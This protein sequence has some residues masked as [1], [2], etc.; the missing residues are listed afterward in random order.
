MTPNDDEPRLAELLRRTDAIADGAPVADTVPT[1][2]PTLDRLLGGGFRR[3]DLI[4]LGGDVGTGKSA[5]ALAIAL[6]AA[7]DGHPV[8][9]LSGEMSPTR[10][11]ERLLAI[12]GRASIDALRS[13]TMDE[14][15]RVSLGAVALRAP[16]TLPVVRAMPQEGSEALDAEA[17]QEP[18]PRLLVIDSLQHVHGTGAPPENNAQAVLALKEIAMRNHV[19]VLV[20]AHL[21]DLPPNREN[22][23]PQLHDFGAMGAIKQLADVVLGLFREEIYHPVPGSEGAAELAILKNRHGPTT[24]I[25][26]YFYKQWL[27]FEDMVDP[28]R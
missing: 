9:Y 22:L 11:Q 13:G 6:R 8:T 12:E 24:Y 3:G 1:G 18:R 25:D 10:V 15:T 5:L 27:R 14:E 20:T 26:L 23:R 16:G 2:F 21:P 7:E 4:V 28:D 17:K 19:A